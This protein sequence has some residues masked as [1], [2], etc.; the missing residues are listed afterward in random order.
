MK[1]ISPLHSV[2]KKGKYGNF[3][4]QIEDDLIKNRKETIDELM[5][6]LNI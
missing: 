1:Q 3:E 6:F 4:N 2:N 5:N